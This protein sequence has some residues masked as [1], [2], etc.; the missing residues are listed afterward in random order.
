M[1][2]LTDELCCLV[3]SQL[4]S[5]TTM[6]LV[7]KKFRDLTKKTRDAA[8]AEKHASARAVLRETFPKLFEMSDD[9]RG[10]LLMRGR[11]TLMREAFVDF[12]RFN[13]VF[14]ETKYHGDS[15]RFIG[16]KKYL[17]KDGRVDEIMCWG[18]LVRC[19]SLVEFVA[20]Y[21]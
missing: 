12:K 7:S 8:K 20:G 15:G 14:V 1:L 17:I 9:R 5:H 2:H 16:Q 4:P 18:G 10:G 19:G 6:S 11:Y 3:L 13:L 21:L